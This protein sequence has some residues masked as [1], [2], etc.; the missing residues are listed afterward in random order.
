MTMQWT[1]D[2]IVRATGGVASAN[3]AANGVTFDSREVEPGDLFVALAGTHSD[4]HDHVPA[5]IARGAAGVLVQRRVDGPMVLCVDTQAGLEALGAAAR[6]RLSDAATVIGVTGSAGKTSVKEALRGVFA[7]VGPTHASVKSYNNH[8]GVPLSLARMPQDTRFAVFEMGMNHAGEIARL[9]RQVRPHI[10]VITTILP[11]HIEN[12]AGLDGIADAKAEI[13]GGLVPG[14]IGVLNADA[15]HFDRLSA[16]ARGVGARVLT[17]GIEAQANVRALGLEEGAEGSSFTVHVDGTWHRVRVPLPGRPRVVNALALIA[18]VHAAGVDVRRAIGALATMEAMPGRGLWH[19]IRAGGGE[20]RLIDESYNANPA[21]MAA[22]LAVLGAAETAGRKLAILGGMRELGERAPEYH[23][24]LVPA[25]LDAR[26]S[27]TLLVG[28]E[29]R[30]IAECLAAATWT[31]DWRA[32]LEV[33]RETI[34]AGDLVLVKGSNS[35]GLGNLV[36]ALTRPE[37]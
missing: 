34:R 4:G 11:A 2:A 17:F 24:A 18:S 35:I 31:P 7:G 19:M 1:S 22:A 3:F 29:T 26:V 36:A 33:A 6:A 30:S 13:F 20:A 32:A 21:A 37:D 12:F 15:A 16:A 9:T 5:A 27:H 23:A 25:I 10:A 28:E 14:G 8:T